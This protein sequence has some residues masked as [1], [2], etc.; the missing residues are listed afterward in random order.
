MAE[1]KDIKI[2]L[3]MQHD[4]YEIR[5]K[6]TVIGAKG[7]IPESDEVIGNYSQHGGFPYDDNI[8]KNLD[9][10]PAICSVLEYGCGPGRNLVRMSSKFSKVSGVDISEQNIANAEILLDSIA[11]K[12]YSLY[13]TPGDSI[14]IFDEKFDLVFEVICLQHVC[15]YSIRRRIL[16]EMV[17]VCQIGG[18]V[19]C[20]FGFNDSPPKNPQYVEYYDD[21]LLG[22]IDTN[23]WADCCVQSE[24]QLKKD[25][26]EIGLEPVDLWYTSM[27]GDIWHDRW[28]W[29]CGRKNR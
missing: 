26:T 1:E 19:V 20:Q 14:P 12:K 15:S 22:V 17:R 9:K 28:V 6:A 27:V 16:S 23:G 2:Y 3:E 25:F 29:I 18:I 24:D 5:A 13:V 7:I 4:R 21:K 8:L 11:V 10:N